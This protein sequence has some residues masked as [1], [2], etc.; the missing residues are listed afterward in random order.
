MVNKILKFHSIIISGRKFEGNYIADK[1]NG[2]GELSWPDGR[3]YAG[4]WLDGV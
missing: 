4:Q 2:F 1:K 3:K